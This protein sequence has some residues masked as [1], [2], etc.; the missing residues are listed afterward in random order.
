[1]LNRECLKP[2]LV[3]II[4]N[5]EGGQGHIIPYHIAVDKVTQILDWKHQ[6]AYSPDS[7]L[8]DLPVD[9]IGCL[10]GAKL[11]KKTHGFSKFIKPFEVIS[12]AKTIYQ[13]LSN[14]VLPNSTNTIIFLERFIHLQLFGLWLAISFLPTEN[15]YIWI[16]YRRDIHNEKTRFIYKI[17]NKLI[18]Y[19]VKPQNFQLLSD[20]EL[21][22]Q[23][24]GYY[25]GE[26][27][28]VMPI[29]HTEFKSKP[30]S[31][32]LL[33]SLNHQQNYPDNN[34]NNN[35]IL[36][37]WAGPPREEKGWS[38]IKNIVNCQCSQANKFCLV[39]AKNSQL[40]SKQGGIKVHLI[41]NNL[42]RLDYEKWLSKSDIILLPYDAKAYQE[43]TSGIFTEAIIA[44]TIPLVTKKSWMANE[45]LKYNLHELI[46]D[47]N[48]PE[49]IFENI[50]KILD[51]S[52]LQIINK[53][54]IMQQEY[55]CFHSLE[56]YAQKF[57]K[58]F[59]N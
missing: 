34:N 43:K 26:T 40:Q 50:E 56:N 45:L 25:F 7:Q 37:W 30:P 44:G 13:F 12:F 5:L 47:W 16:L 22:A 35:Y 21:L 17:L 8:T 29:P 23:S 42:T 36:C 20:S 53:F 54:Q 55:R 19:K 4:P 6:V 52:C 51:K 9:W 31:F 57:Y 10:D 28:K 11:E 41:P 39:A 32:S 46:I 48:K 59:I 33:K 27:L 49:N 14:Q 38:I 18:K 3:S 2:T 58:L 15:L 1:M 24:L